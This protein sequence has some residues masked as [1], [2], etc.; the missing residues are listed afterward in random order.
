M[1]LHFEAPDQPDVV[2][3]IAELDAYQDQLYP[4]ECRYATDLTA[5]R[6][7]QVWLAVARDAAGQA[8]GCGALVLHAEFG[9]IK[10]MY[11]RPGQRGQ[12]LARRTLALLEA[13]AGALGCRRLMLETGPRQPEALALYARCGY[14]RRARSQ[15]TV[16]T[17]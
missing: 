17:R 1:Q 16:T 15:T 6:S 5:L 7:E 14:Q 2:A 13:Q 3:L 11:V 9:E 8:I 10:R 4:P 12:G